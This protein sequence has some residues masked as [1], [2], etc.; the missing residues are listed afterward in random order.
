MSKQVEIKDNTLI[1]H[2]REDYET[3]DK[4]VCVCMGKKKRAFYT[5]DNLT[6][7]QVKDWTVCGFPVEELIKLSMF[8]NRNDISNYDLKDYNEAFLSGYKRAQEDIHKQIQDSINRMINDEID[9]QIIK[10]G[11]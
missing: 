10:G 8:L 4:V 2:T 3:I 6:L 11:L 1:V 5:N 7:A 9:N